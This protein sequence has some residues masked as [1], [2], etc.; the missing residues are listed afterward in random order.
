MLQE[1]FERAHGLV[2]PTAIVYAAGC[3]KTS[4]VVEASEMPGQITRPVTVGSRGMSMGAID[5]LND[6]NT[7]A[8]IVE[9]HS[10]DLTSDE[11]AIDG[12]QVLPLSPNS[13]ETQSPIVGDDAYRAS[14]G[15]S[16]GLAAPYPENN[17]EGQGRSS[18]KLQQSQLHM[19][20]PTSRMAGRAEPSISMP[21]KESLEVVYYLTLNISTIT[22]KE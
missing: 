4:V 20:R 10:F 17:L 5:P 16:P 8:E 12:L 9:V 11:N 19:P 15:G 1:L 21:T 13:E 14:P 6:D 3:S 7:S 22:D 18:A 2:A